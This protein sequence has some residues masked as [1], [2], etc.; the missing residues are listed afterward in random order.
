MLVQSSPESQSGSRGP[1][2]HSVAQEQDSIPS[3]Q[4]GA[5]EPTSIDDDLA[6]YLASATASTPSNVQ[7]QD[8][9]KA[10][11]KAMQTRF[12]ASVAAQLERLERAIQAAEEKA[13]E[14]EQRFR[15]GGQVVKECQTDLKA[16]MNAETLTSSS[17]PL[18]EVEWVK[19]ITDLPLQMQLK[20]GDELIKAG[21]A[22]HAQQL[23]DDD[24][25]QLQVL[26][27]DDVDSR[28]FGHLLKYEQQSAQAQSKK[29]SSSPQEADA[30]PYNV[31]RQADQGLLGDNSA[32]EPSGARRMPW[33][34]T[35]PRHRSRRGPIAPRS[36]RRDR[37]KAEPTLATV[38]GEDGD[39]TAMSK[40]SAVSRE[41]PTTQDR[42]S[43]GRGDANGTAIGDGK[44]VPSTNAVTTTPEAEKVAAVRIASSS[45]DIEVKTP[46]V[47]HTPQAQSE[48]VV[49]T[50]A[51]A[52]QSDEIEIGGDT[53]TLD[54]TSQGTPVHVNAGGSRASGKRSASETGEA[55]T[56]VL[57]E[58][59]SK[60]AKTKKPSLKLRL[61]LA[62]AAR[63]DA[64]H[65]KKQDALALST[66]TASVGHRSNVTSMLTNEN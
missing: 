19:E 56:Y 4:P 44:S 33:T 14:V 1:S 24:L 50:T 30:L 17:R 55:N 9:F 52:K 13:I 26:T 3:S 37:A 49:A 11:A 65:H 10:G 6:I 36:G 58:P 18:T 45:D 47:Q 34:S 35:S 2:Q 41:E 40:V 43:S 60:Q 59:D 27:D 20:I 57:M 8:A 48:S 64:D 46:V 31:F 51:T 29:A 39:R 22:Q 66:A 16:M 28:L 7:V 32:V 42:G 38:D 62:N 5:V 61:Q 12:K 53:Q 54:A 21:E 25:A 23:L 15:I 63:K